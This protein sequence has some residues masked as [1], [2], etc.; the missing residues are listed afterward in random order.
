MGL[1]R[2]RRLAG[3]VDEQQQGTWRRSLACMSGILWSTGLVV[4][5]S[6]V[7]GILY[8]SSNH[9]VGVSALSASFMRDK[10]QNFNIRCEEYLS[11]EEKILQKYYPL[12]PTES[13]VHLHLPFT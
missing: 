4:L 9:S 10:V 8:N 11:C 2:T 3:R 7:S 5:S 13:F 12:C 6:C 1:S